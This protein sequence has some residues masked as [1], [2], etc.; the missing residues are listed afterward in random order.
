MSNSPLKNRF[1][2]SLRTDHHQRKRDEQLVHPDLWL[3]TLEGVKTPEQELLERERW[4]RLDHHIDQLPPRCA[5]ALRLKYGL[6]CEPH[7]LEQ[8]GEVFGVSRERIRQIVWKGESI[9]RRRMLLE[10]NP[11]RLRDMVAREKAEEAFKK[12]RMDAEWEALCRESKTQRDILAVRTDEA[13]REMMPALIREIERKREAER[14]RIRLR[15]YDYAYHE[16]HA[17][18]AGWQDELE[19]RE[20]EARLQQR[21]AV[22][23]AEYEQRVK[24]LVARRDALSAYPA[25]DPKRDWLFVA[26]KEHA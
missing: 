20:Q 15:A 6:R 21:N 10:E 24:A 4:R 11:Q 23:R 5:L 17:V 2:V 9:L 1:N 3:A 22:R 25:A 13:A 19:R 7:T 14:E 18:N 26:S 16:A 8:V 12:A